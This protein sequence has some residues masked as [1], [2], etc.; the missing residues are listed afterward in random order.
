M[1]KLW[2]GGKSLIQWI[3]YAIILFQ[4][5]TYKGWKQRI[6][7][8][9]KGKK[10]L[11]LL[12]ISLL[13]L[14]GVNAIAISLTEIYPILNWGWL[15][16]NIVFGPSNP[17]STVQPTE[18]TTISLLGNTLYLAFTLLIVACASLIFNYY[19]EEIFR[20]K[21][22]LVPAWALLHLVMGIPIYAVI[23]IF[24]VGILYKIIYDK[25]S[26]QHAYTLH[27]STN[28]SLLLIVVFLYIL[29][30]IN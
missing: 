29:Q 26:L 8:I 24:S 21:W 22:W 17:G 10:A 12:P 25:Y 16:Y 2:S 3:L 6:K 18:T 7:D 5:A 20:K 11:L 4:I 23:P 14:L 19:E 9:I 28:M 13:I 1:S 30:V 27:L 15:G